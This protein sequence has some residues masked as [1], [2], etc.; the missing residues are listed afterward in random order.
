MVISESAH[1]VTTQYIVS[2]ARFSAFTDRLVALSR[3]GIAG[4]IFK[5]RGTHI[6]S[7]VLLIT[8][9]AAHILTTGP[10]EPHTRKVTIHRGAVGSA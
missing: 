9:S 7:L 8:V 10:C 1:D 2:K 5:S 4:S 6:E 3:V